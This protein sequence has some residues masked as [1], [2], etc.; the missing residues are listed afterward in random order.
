[1]SNLF[2][3]KRNYTNLTL[4]PFSYIIPSVDSTYNGILLLLVPQIIML[5]ITKSYNSLLVVG[6]SVLGSCAAEGAYAYFIKSYPFSWVAVCIQGII[7]GMLLPSSYPLV[8]VFFITFIILLIAKYAFGGYANSW[9]NP[10]AVVVAVAYFIN[11]SAFPTYLVNIADLQSRNTALTLIQNGTI[12]IS[13]VD[14]S[15]TA[16]LNHT[17]F[18]LAGVSI[19]DGYVSLFWD[20][21]SIIPAFRFNFITLVSSIILISLDMVDVYIPACFIVVYSLLVR[22]VEPLIVHGNPGQ[23]DIL[24]AL[25]TSGTLFSTLFILQWYGTTPISKTGK[26]LYGIIAGIMAFII[27]GCGTS[28]AGYVFTVLIMNLIS[29][30]IQV[31]ESKVVKRRIEKSIVPRIKAMREVNNG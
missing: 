22:F 25:L 6:L 21:N 1:M 7:I 26:I 28:P 5:L 31:I 10:A 8:A 4:R 11:M 16:F 18:S 24:L 17:I 27:I 29:P 14:S 20:C 9:L 13:S 12:P 2:F 15:I 23:G 19:P 30:F 3:T